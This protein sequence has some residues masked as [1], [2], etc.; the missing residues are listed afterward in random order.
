MNFNF[1][2]CYLSLEFVNEKKLCSQF[3]KEQLLNN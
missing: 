2:V 3:F 1:V